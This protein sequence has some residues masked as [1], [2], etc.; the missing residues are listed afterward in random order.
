[1]AWLGKNDD[2]IPTEKFVIMLGVVETPIVV[3]FNFAPGQQQAPANRRE[4]G[5][6]D[7]ATSELTDVARQLRR[8]VVRSQARI[9]YDREWQLTHPDHAAERAGSIAATERYIAICE[10]GLQGLAAEYGA[11][12]EAPETNLSTD[13]RQREGDEVRR[14]MAIL[15][16]LLDYVRAQES[17]PTP[18][19]ERGEESE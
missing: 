17:P 2:R 13:E 12:L 3:T 6:I 7:A 5:W 1:M 14:S 10:E 9:V 18:E 4:V 16:D 19:A 15:S 11:V 8:M